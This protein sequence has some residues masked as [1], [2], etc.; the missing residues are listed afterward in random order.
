[1]HAGSPAG[2]SA[3]NTKTMRLLLAEDDPL[4][5]RATCLGLM[6]AGYAVDWVTT[7]NK[8]IGAL[9]DFAYDCVLLDLGLPELSGEACLRNVRAQRNAVPIIVLT[10]RALVGDRVNMLDQG[11][12]DYLVKP[13]DLDELTARVRAV[14]RRGQ[15][16][17]MEQGLTHGP[18]K[19][20]P[21]NRNVL[22]HGKV[23][24]LTSKE[25]WALEALVRRRGAPMTRRQLEEA[26][27]SW[28]EEIGS[29]AVEVHVHHLRRKIH[30]AVVV[31]QRGAGYRVGDEAVL[32]AAVPPQ[33]RETGE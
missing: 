2:G 11:A 6:Q 4:L 16:A 17:N 21:L 5:G 29:N 7:G 20:M 19:L 1:M 23:V 28:N 22:W 31:T 25:F 32:A 12:D 9:R 15:T 14:V 8:L 3:P 10:A 30:P 13:F 33:E 27:Y 18:L 24:Q 26:L